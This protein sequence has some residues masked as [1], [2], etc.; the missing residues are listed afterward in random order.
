M[1]VFV[2]IDVLAMFVINT[3]RCFVGVCVEE[4]NG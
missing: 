4:R 2:N 1:N 3:Y